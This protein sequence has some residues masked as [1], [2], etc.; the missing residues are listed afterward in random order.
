MSRV[1]VYQGDSREI[2]RV[3]A[4]CSVDAVVTD[5]PYALVSIGKRF[6]ADNAAPAKSDGPTGVYARASAG[7]MGRQWDTGETAFAVEFWGEVHRVLK[8]GGFVVAF[9]GTRTYHRLACAIEDAGFEIR[10]M[11]SWLYGSG[12]PKSKDVAASIDSIDADD[13]RR[14]RALMFTAWMRS[15][16]LGVDQINGLTGTVMASHYLSEKSQP[17]I[18]TL[19][20][21]DRLRPFL[22]AVPAWVEELVLQR[23]VESQNMKAREVV[24]QHDQSAQAALWREKFQGGEAA[25]PGLITRAYSPEAQAFEGWGTALK[26][27]CEPCV[28]ARKGLEGTLGRN[29]LAYGVG[30]LNIDACRVGTDGGTVFAGLRQGSEH[31]SASTYGDGLNGK[32]ATAVKG[33]G[34]WPANVVH[35]GSDE[36]VHAFPFSE[37][38][39]PRLTKRSP[40]GDGRLGYGAFGGQPEVVIGPG[41]SGS[42]AR[43]FYSAKAD[44]EDR[45]GSEHPTVKPV[46][47][48]AWLVRLTCPRGGVVLDP[49]AGSGTTGLAAMREGCDAILIEREADHADDIRRRI[50]WARGEAGLTRQEILRHD[51]AKDPAKAEGADLPLFGDPVAAPTGGGRPDNTATSLETARGP[52]VVHE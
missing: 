39:P 19:D 8:P 30:G 28:L 38:P 11:I 43:F 49:F 7:F 1:D 4:D 52:E 3:I 21:F 41:D 29:V 22:P 18:P 47:L 26:P 33:L 34:R 12:F 2:L 42:A 31:G 15:T 46:D 51:L 13:E 5:P 20:L 23:T 35:D 44:T 17:S 27:A 25:A 37:S 45:L 10:D 14:A 6:G 48:M 40:D 36:V 24:G 9:S 32:L 16:G 50:A